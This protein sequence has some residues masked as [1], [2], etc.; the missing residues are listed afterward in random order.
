VIRFSIHRPV[1]VTMAYTAVAALGAFAWRNIPIELIPDTRLPRLTVGATWRGASPETVEAFLTSP[2]EAV[3]QQVK[4]V[5]KITSISSEQQG[6]GTSSIAVEFGR[7]VDMDFARLEL[8]ERISTLEEE[9]PPGVGVV[10]VQTY[11]PDE[12]REQSI[13]FLRY[14]F[15]G[16]Y[17]LEALRAHVDDVVRPALTEVEG[18]G[19]VQV[20]GGRARRLEIRLDPEASRSLGLSPVFLRQRIAELDLVQEAG[21]VREGEREWTVTIANR[22]GSAEDI[23]DAIVATAGEKAVRVRDVAAI[24]DT[25][26]EAS[27][28]RRIDGE[29]AVTFEVVKEIGTNTVSVADRVK[30]TMTRLEGLA[31]YGSSYVLVDDESE[32][33]RRQLSDLRARAGGSALVIF[34]V[35]FAFLRSFASAT[36]VFST[37]GFSVLITLNLIYFGGLSLNLLTLMGLAMGFGLLVD[38]CIV[39]L[40]NIYRRWQG[41]EAPALAAEE[42]SRDVV[43]PI[44]ASTATN[45]IVFVPFV[46]LQGEM[47]MF[48]V[49]LAIVVGLSQLASFVVGFTFIP[50]LS[51]R[52][53]GRRVRAAGTAAAPLPA[54]PT[55]PLYTRFYAALVGWTLRHPWVTVSVA[56]AMF[57]GSAWLFDKYV[58]R[59]VVWGGRGGTDTYIDISIRLPRGS[60]LDRTDELVR[61]FEEKIAPIPEVERFTSR[62]QGQF[63]SIQITF[64]DSL[65]TTFVPV[66]IKEEMVGYSHSFTGADVRVYGYGPSFYGGGGAAPNYTVQVL[67]YNYEKVRDIAEDLGA[68]LSRMARIDAVDTNS[69]GR[70]TLDRAVEYTVRIDRDALARFDMSVQDLVG[71]LQA[72][73]GGRSGEGTL[74]LGGEEVRYQVKL[75]GSEDADVLALL[76]T[77]IQLP[78]GRQVRLGDVVTVEPREVLASVVRE[79][80]QYRR[81]VAYEFRG[82][83]KLG[84]AVLDAMLARTEVPAGY[85]VEK[86]EGFYFSQEEKEQI[87]LV[88]A[89]SLLLIYM[90]TAAVFE[91]FV[92]PLCVLLTVP[93]G[94]VGTFLVFFYTNATFTREAYVGVIMAGGIV[95]NNAI[96]LIDHVNRMRAVPGLA[97]DEAV[98]RGTLQRVRPILMTSA[99]TVVGLGPLVLFSDP[100]ANIWNALGFTLIGGLLSSTL[101]VLTVTPALYKLFERGGVGVRAPELAGVA[102]ALAP[103][104]D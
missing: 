42:G 19:V 25:Y 30:A 40:E 51:A 3:I 4:G 28:Y 89:V 48:Y 34:L 99:T 64:P 75:E 49:P 53:L 7:D 52:L 33:I 103:A 2:L 73:V 20:M 78:D 76:E 62:V 63:G 79:N 95:V 1:A 54:P 60:N 12:L 18:V 31:P 66:A 91:S 90:V 93:M 27:E 38:N 43:M 29:P 68:R 26:E 13:P 55:P 39:V 61:F 23:L 16:P 92:Q 10:Q 22:P 82:P 94:L 80:Q 15:T 45:L 50:A 97:F 11:I 74:K 85:T 8:S 84:D 58:T 67:G 35:L 81:Q 47:R 100:D 21:V 72:A 41:G 24:S 88:L 104:G 32:D 71:R 98:I 96:L 56:A 6:M 37:I 14:N 69:S 46:Y 44:L 101:L 36:V 59:G 70:F 77:L 5:E 9:L 57:G 83:V 86:A 65:E 102:P 17:T 87:Y